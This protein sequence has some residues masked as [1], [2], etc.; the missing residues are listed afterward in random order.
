MD[1]GGG[2]E[3]EGV[4]TPGVEEGAAGVCASVKGVTIPAMAKSMAAKG[5]MVAGRS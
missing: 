4:W 1:A 5:F 3:S 2:L